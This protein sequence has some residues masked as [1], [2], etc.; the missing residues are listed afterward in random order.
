MLGTKQLIVG[1]DTVTILTTDE[2]ELVE[3]STVAKVLQTYYRETLNLFIYLQTF[4]D[5]GPRRTDKRPRGPLQ[6]SLSNGQS[7]NVRKKTR[8]TIQINR[9]IN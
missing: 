9:S 1:K 5:D 8:K 6:G 7:S 3:I 4:R 2:P